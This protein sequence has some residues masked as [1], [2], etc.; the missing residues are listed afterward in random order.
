MAL[1]SGRVW[2]VHASGELRAF[3]PEGVLQ[4][5]LMADSSP[6][7]LASDGARLWVAHRAG[8][9]TQ[10]EAS[11]GTISARWELPCA[12]CSIQGIHWDGVHLWLSDFSGAALLR[13]DV[14]SGEMVSLPA[15]ANSPTALTSDAH[16]LLVL[17]QG[18]A[19]GEGVILTRH[20]RPSGETTATLES[21]TFPTALVSDGQTVFLAL[22]SQ[23]A[24]SLAR[25]DALTLEAR[26]QIEAPPTGDLLLAGGRLW[27]AD[28]SA[29]T[30]TRRDPATL[31][32]LESEPAEG[33]P[34]ALA[35]GDGFLWIVQR[36]AGLLTRLWIG[37]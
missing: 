27:S 10:I 7:G 6:T 5:S 29:G 22:R 12:A 32:R 24:G 9:V 15:G 35:Y 4:L 21:E 36:R 28:V 23:Q 30:V 37:P 34:Q 3:S 20:A 16:G 18:L 2:V 25:Y 31:T 11:T 8:T 26:G 14:D 1:A 19:A 13:V 17:H 33:L